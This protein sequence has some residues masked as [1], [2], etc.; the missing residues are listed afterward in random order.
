MFCVHIASLTHV[1]IVFFSI[2][3]GGVAQIV[4]EILKH[5]VET[6]TFF[7][8]EEMLISIVREQMPD[9]YNCSDLAGHLYDCWEDNR[10][11]WVKEAA[12][13]WFTQDRFGAE[14]PAQ[15]LFDV[16][17]TRVA[18]PPEAEDLSTFV[19]AL[20]NGLSPNGALVISLGKAPTILHP[21]GDIGYYAS[22]EKLFRSLESQ[23]EVDSMMVFEDDFSLGDTSREVVPD[24]FLVVCKSKRCRQRFYAAPEEIDSQ[25]VMRAKNGNLKM[26]FYDGAL[27]ASF[28]VVPKAYETVYCRR[29]PMPFECAYRTMDY[30]RDLFEFDEAPGISQF[31]LKE[32]G[33]FA[34]V[35]IPEGSFIMA[36]DLARSLLVSVASVQAVRDSE[37]DESKTNFLRYIDTFS[38]ASNDDADQRIVEIGVSHLIRSSESGEEANIGRWVPSQ[39]RP[40]YSPVYDRHSGSFD[41]FLV[42]TK[43]IPVG[44][45]LVKLAATWED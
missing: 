30:S 19:G 4:P 22:H 27:H 34:T 29:D 26:I 9:T 23:S 40:A 7:Q 41:V 28:Q 39:K 24:A 32:S 16:I 1:A 5:E 31:S 8:P 15:K 33:V 35:D 37:D 36:K 3:V 38:H 45:E 2:T 14:E 11:T 20:M 25:L 44:G 42:A 43:D 6:V 17:Y 12:K 18:Q 13:S 10:F 21:R